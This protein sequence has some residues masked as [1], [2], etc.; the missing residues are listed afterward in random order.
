VIVATD[1]RVEIEGLREF[2]R[3]LRRLDSGIDREL[4]GSI[5][6]AA[7]KVAVTAAGLAPR[8]TGALA[9]SIRPYVSGARAS[10]GSRLPYAGVVH[11]GGMIRPRGV[12]ISFKPTEFISRAVESHA[13]ALVDDLGDAIEHAARRAGWH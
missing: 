12:P 4:R 3:D 11:F 2:R 7:G 1:V 10:V 13:N 8:R 5:R 6:E 9:R